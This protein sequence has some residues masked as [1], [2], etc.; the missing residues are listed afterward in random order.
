MCS[1]ELFIHFTCFSGH[2]K[3]DDT[4][5]RLDRIEEEQGK[6]M[7]LVQ[8]QQV[9]LQVQNESFVALQESIGRIE[10][11][12]FDPS[13]NDNSNNREESYQKTP[14]HIK[15]RR[16][17]QRTPS[18]ARQHSIGQEGGDEQLQDQPESSHHVQQQREVQR[19]TRRKFLKLLLIFYFD[20]LTIKP[21]SKRWFLSQRLSEM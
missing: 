19:E 20:L 5:C 11:R 8:Q 1:Y 2:K 13:R 18:E 3:N 6:M 14:T 21:L 10:S 12:W 15:R 9:Q 16:R 7:N 4:T 17:Q